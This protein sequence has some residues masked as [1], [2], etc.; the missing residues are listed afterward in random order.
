MDERCAAA[1]ACAGAP[2]A[3]SHA[4]SRGGTPQRESG[5]C[6]PL[7][8]AQRTP[9][10]HTRGEPRTRVPPAAP[11]LAVPNRRGK[12]VALAG[13]VNHSSRRSS[14]EGKEAVLT[15]QRVL[16]SST[17]ATEG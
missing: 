11:P 1:G 3:P 7:L 16:C 4:H 6:R 5:L 2:L 14:R 10:A 8:R 12:G 17:T 13:Q 9:A 15:P